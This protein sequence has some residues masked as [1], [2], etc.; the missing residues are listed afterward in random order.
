MD[1]KI[2]LFMFE[3]T[4]LKVFFNDNEMESKLIFQGF[5]DW[6]ITKQLSSS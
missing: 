4:D 6:K 5:K 3:N 2:E 1:S